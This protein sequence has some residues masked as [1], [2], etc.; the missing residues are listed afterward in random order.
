MKKR[1]QLQHLGAG[2][3]A[4]LLGFEQAIYVVAA[5]TAASAIIAATTLSP[6][7]PAAAGQLTEVL[8]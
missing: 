8:A 2:A 4:D 1:T 7:R 3:V 5:L 6:A